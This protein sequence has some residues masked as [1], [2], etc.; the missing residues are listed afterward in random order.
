MAVHVAVDAIAAGVVTAEC[1]TVRYPGHESPVLSGMEMVIR[2]GEFVVIAGPSGSGKS[3]FCHCLLGLIPNLTKGEIVGGRIL[4]CG[5]DTRGRKV[6]ELAQTVCMVFQDPD[7]NIFSLIVLD[8]LAFGPE[9][10]GMDKADII[11][12]V[13]QASAWVGIDD[14]WTRR[15]DQLS[16]GQKQRVAIASSLALQPRILVLDE[17]TT[18]LDPAGKRQVIDTLVR[19]RSSLGISIIVI[20]HDLSNL[21]QVA[22]RLIIVG[23]AGRVVRDGP[24]GRVLAEGYDE[25]E[26]LGMRIPTCARIGHLLSNAAGGSHRIT[27]SDADALALVQSHPDRARKALDRLELRP[28]RSPASDRAV[29]LQTDDLRF[30]Y[31]RGKPV[32]NGVDLSVQQG[33]F[34]ALVGPN[35]SGKST[36]LKLLVGL[37]RPKSEQS[38]RMWSPEGVPLARRQRAPQVSYVFQDPNHQ[39]FADTVWDEVAFGLVLRNEQPEVIEQRLA[40]VLQRVNLLR[41]RDRHPA[42][43]SRGEKRRLAVATALCS[44]I[45]LLLLDEPT[46]GQD[47]KTLDGLFGILQ[48]LNQEQG[49]TVIFVTH[50]MLTVWTYASQIIGLKDGRVRVQGRTED[51]LR[52]VN[53]GLLRELE[54]RLPLEAHLADLLTGADHPLR[55]GSDAIVTALSGARGRG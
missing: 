24:P 20:E 43:L 50:D 16:G 33:E 39:L 41:Y 26:K 19:L 51:L 52:P 10:M 30:E 1:L 7:T 15:T 44:P 49:T 14:L 46:T 3:T 9:N 29:I 34:V 27:L 28:A 37:L 11:R 13:E 4:I 5:Q 38:I 47:R 23:E 18:D 31:Q 12:R 35:G 21:L 53:D 6:H 45:Q 2:E 25:L 48:Q 22:D 17:P 40:E 54:L 55:P 36:L 42:T 32:L 8:E